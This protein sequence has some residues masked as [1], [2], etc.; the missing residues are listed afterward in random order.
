[1]VKTNPGFKSDNLLTMNL[2]LPVQ[3]IRTRR[4]G[5]LFTRKL[6]RRVEG[7]PGVESAAAVNHLP[8]GGSNSSNLL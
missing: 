7:L 8:L 1:M 6:V 2:V 4:R 3:S 5:R